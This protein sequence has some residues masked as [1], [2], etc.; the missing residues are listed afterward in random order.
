MAK[1]V[2]LLRMPARD[3]GALCFLP[4]MR[5]FLACFPGQVKV[6]LAAESSFLALSHQVVPF[7]LAVPSEAAILCK[8]QRSLRQFLTP[9]PQ[10]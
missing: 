8:V 3:L 7:V 4:E 5:Q 9:S 10:A 2:L 6:N 1:Q